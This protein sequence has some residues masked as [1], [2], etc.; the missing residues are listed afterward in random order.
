[1]RLNYIAVIRSVGE[2]TEKL[3]EYSLIN[4]GIPKENIFYVRNIAPFSEALKESYRIAIKTKA[5]IAIIIDADVVLMPDIVLTINNIIAFYK[6]QWFFINLLIYDFISGLIRPGGPKFYNIKYLELALNMIENETVS[7]RPETYV[8]K[9]MHR[10]GYQIHY[11][12]IPSAFH[13]FAQY[14]KHLFQKSINIYW[15]LE[16]KRDE[17]YKR[18]VQ[19]ET[20]DKDWYVVKRA[21]DYARKNVK[22]LKLD[23]RYYNKVFESLDIKEKGCIENMENEYND[24]IMQEKEIVQFFGYTNNFLESNNCSKYSFIYNIYKKWK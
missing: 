18:A 17:I 1:M 24:L 19:L 15:K 12:D 22:Q 13:D 16:G 6:H 8:T 5:D 23:F 20:I 11:L 9:K 21:F 2:R 10:L 4:N 14:R 7:I 3:C